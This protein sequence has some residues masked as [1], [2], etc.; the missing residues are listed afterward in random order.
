M[1]DGDKRFCMADVMSG[2]WVRFYQNGKLVIGAV[3]YIR[4]EGVINERVV[5][6]TDI[7]ATELSAVLEARTK[8]DVHIED[9]Q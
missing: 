9:G 7:G 5:V 2:D 4:A 8:L 3:Q 6:Y 1:N